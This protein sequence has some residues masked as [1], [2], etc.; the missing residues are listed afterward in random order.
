VTVPG[1]AMVPYSDRAG[2]ISTQALALDESADEQAQAKKERDAALNALYGTAFP[3]I[4]ENGDAERDGPWVAWASALWQNRE[5]SMT[6]P[7]WIA[8][9]NREMWAGRQWIDS[10]A[11]GRKW[12]TPRA[13][14][15]A[16][17]F[18]V[19]VTKAALDLRAQ[20]VSEQR[21]GFSVEPTNR[22]AQSKKKAEAK[23]LALEYAW[24]EMGMEQIMGELAHWSSTDGVAFTET[25]WDD[26][27][28]P[29]HEML[30]KQKIRLG[31]VRKRVLRMDEVRV[32]PNATATVAPNWICVHRIVPT[33][34]AV[35]RWGES[36]AD[37]A[38][39]DGALKGMGTQGL[40]NFTDAGRQDDRFLD[41]P[42]LDEFAVYCAQTDH[43]PNGLE[44]HAVGQKVTYLGELLFG[45]IPIS[46]YTDGSKDPAYYPMPDMNN[47][48]DDQMGINSVVSKI[49]ETVR[50]TAGGAFLARP[51]AMTTETRMLGALS[52]IEVQ[53]TGALDDVVKYLPPS[54]VGSDA[55]ALLQFLMA[56]FEQKSGWND[57]TRGSFKSDTSG[58][59]ILAIREQVERIFAPL[60]GAFARGA[61]EDAK[62]TLAAMMWGYELPRE[63]AITGKSRIDLA[64]QIS[65]EDLDGVSDVTIDP[66]SLMPMPKS[67]KLSLMQQDLEKGL[68]PPDQYLRLRPFA[69]MRDVGNGDEDD[70]ARAFRIADAIRKGMPEAQLNEQYPALPMDNAAVHMDILRREILLDD[71]LP[72]EVKAVAFDRYMVYQQ[73]QQQQVA[74]QPGTP[75]ANYQNALDKLQQQGIA[76]LNTEA[77][78]VIT[79]QDGL[80]P[81]PSPAANKPRAMTGPAPKKAPMKKGSSL[82]PMQAPTST[83]RGP[84]AAA[85]LV[86]PSEEQHAG[87]AFDAASAM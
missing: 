14:G 66:E 35:A 24:K 64:Q 12:I 55:M 52:L 72:K 56:Q 75:E 34:E 58:R 8:Q 57:A 26:N 6:Y 73:M 25:Y 9:R 44:L 10:T 71:W 70:R 39:K 49:I 61:V 1:M 46:R 17:R 23:Q 22:D 31:D 5:A 30:T 59:A 87:Q 40:G 36:V 41:T 15:D 13:P 45:R 33:N 51:Q 78:K 20:I 80:A 79:A 29:W 7:L 2:G 74:P 85:P 65:A 76:A 86:D 83:S 3:L 48:V 38:T 11:V 84:V 4:S 32:S 37:Q 67:L 27:A 18:V 60:V 63:I 54:A 82:D 43:L 81:L 68:I 21:P 47:W 62:N 28:G 69:W 16:V 50:R 77:L 19:N 42:T 53:G